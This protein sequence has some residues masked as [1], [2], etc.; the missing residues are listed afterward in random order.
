MILAVRVTGSSFQARGRCASGTNS[1]GIL[2]RLM[3]LQLKRANATTLLSVC[4]VPLSQLLLI[5]CGQHVEI[6]STCPGIEK[7]YLVLQASSVS[8]C[9]H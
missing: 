4:L 7:E 3:K 8:S 9:M 1:I 6:A 5:A 2:A